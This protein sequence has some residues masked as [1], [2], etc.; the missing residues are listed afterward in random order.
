[1]RLR[2]FPQ[3][4][5]AIKGMQSY[6]TEMTASHVQSEEDNRLTIC[7]EQYHTQLAI[8]TLLI[9]FH[10]LQGPTAAAPQYALD[11]HLVQLTGIKSDCASLSIRS[12][13]RSKY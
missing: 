12:H 10:T 3:A 8:F 11:V 13:G 7:K 4:K 1:M 9:T 2:T 5:I 6:A